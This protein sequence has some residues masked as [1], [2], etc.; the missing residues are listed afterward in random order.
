MEKNRELLPLIVSTGDLLF[1]N[2]STRDDVSIVPVPELE[3]AA[4]DTGRIRWPETA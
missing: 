4:T 2:Y 1:N 3:E